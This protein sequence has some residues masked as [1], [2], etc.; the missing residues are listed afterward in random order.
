MHL[1]M[2]REPTCTLRQAHFT[3]EGP[4]DAAVYRRAGRTRVHTWEWCLALGAVFL[5]PVCGPRQES[6]P[7]AA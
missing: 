6:P 3:A 4:S 1:L 5:A 7:S 2:Q